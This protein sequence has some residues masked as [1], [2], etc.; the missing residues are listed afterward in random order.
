ML[1][2]LHDV[3]GGA[4]IPRPRH[5]ESLQ[6]GPLARTGCN[7]TLHYVCGGAPISRPRHLESVQ[8]GP[9]A[10]TGCKEWM[11]GG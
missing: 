8:R 2:T 5:T 4:P 1:E 7:A 9:L 3:F 10:W 6:R 11:P